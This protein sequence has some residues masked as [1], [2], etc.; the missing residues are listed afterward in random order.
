VIQT[1]AVRPIRRRD[2]VLGKWLGHWIVMAGY[3]ALL[4]GG[5]LA[6]QSAL[7]GFTPPRIAQGLPLG[8][9][10]GTVFLTVSIAGGARLGPVGAQHGDGRL[11]GRLHRGRIGSRHP[12][13]RPPSAVALSLSVRASR[14][15]LL[16]ELQLGA[17]RVVPVRHTVAARLFSDSQFQASWS[18]LSG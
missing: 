16:V 1:I 7:A 14:A 4:A 2:V 3:F 15:R 9:L 18:R 11:G 8:L 13:V 10:E 17:H 12:V 5:V 6:L